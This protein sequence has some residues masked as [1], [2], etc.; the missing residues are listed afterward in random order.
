MWSRDDQK[1]TCAQNYEH[2]FTEKKIKYIYRYKF[3]FENLDKY[4]FKQQINEFTNELKDFKFEDLY[5]KL[6]DK[7]VEI[8]NQFIDTLYSKEG[9]LS[10]QILTQVEQ[11]VSNDGQILYTVGKIL[12]KVEKNEENLAKILSTT[13]ND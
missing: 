7:K 10:K 3:Q 6:L 11:A 5:E 12:K 4:E 1:L 9:Q 8:T 2:P 13:K